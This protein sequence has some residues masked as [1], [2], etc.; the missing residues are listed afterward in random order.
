M[1]LLFYL[2]HPAHY[3]LFRNSISQLEGKGHSIVILIKKKDILEELLKSSGSPYLNI[4]PE[5]R[6]D[7][8]AG[9]AWGL[10]KRD[11]R[12]FRHCL[13]HRPDLMIGTSTEITHVGKV[14]GIP[15]V[16]V[17]EDD[18]GV[19]PFYS[20]LSYPFAGCILSPD[21]CNNGKWTNKTVS[22]PGYHELAYLHPELFTPSKEIAARYV[23][24][25]EP[26]YILRFAKLTAH[27]DTGIRG[28]SPEIARQIIRLLEPSGRVYITSERTL[29]EEFEP[30]RLK[31]NVLDIHHVMAFAR[32]YIG[33]SQTMAA[34]AGVLGTP[35]IRFND[36]VGRIGYLKD[37]EEK[38]ELGVGIPAGQPAQLYAVVSELASRQDAGA[39]WA[40]KR[41]R[42]LSGKINT[43]RFM[44]WFFENYPGSAGECR[45]A[46]FDWNQFRN[47]PATDH[48]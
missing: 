18:A 21:V 31:V 35:F 41:T 36:F 16:N 11:L 37:L 45:K 28:I 38:W 5:G 32:L 17:N 8:R 1:R 34:E 26:Y 6:K 25:D 2:G 30:C 9:I 14:L 23:H 20:K 10:A 46:G 44:T 22:Y 29:E 13:S 27:H 47:L 33:D 4:L 12:L 7:S 43:A 39:E 42:M 24:P 40:R 48:Q 3:H 15:S 19:V